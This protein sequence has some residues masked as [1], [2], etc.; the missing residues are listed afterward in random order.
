MEI[1]LQ[2]RQD[3]NARLEPGVYLPPELCLGQE[4]QHFR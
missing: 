4:D 2:G 1:R 3:G